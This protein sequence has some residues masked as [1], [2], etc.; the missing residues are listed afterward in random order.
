[1]RI[2]VFLCRA[3][4]GSP[5]P[6]FS[7]LSRLCR[8]VNS[9]FSLVLDFWL[10]RKTV[11]IGN[12]AELY[13]KEESPQY[14]TLDAQNYNSA[15]DQLAALKKSCTL[16]VGNLS[17]FSKEMQIYET[18]SYV[19]PVKRL[20]MGLNSNT[21]TPCG[22]CF[23]EYYTQEAAYMALKYVS[24]TV[25]DDRIIRC[26]ADPGYLPGRQFGRG[27]SGGQVRDEWRNDYDPGRGRFILPEVISG[28]KRR[29][30][31]DDDNEGPGRGRYGRNVRYERNFTGQQRT[32]GTPRE[33][34]KQQGHRAAQREV[35]NATVKLNQ[36]LSAAR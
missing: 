1:M 29:R 5:R 25:C 36:S 23:V 34:R 33:S 13:H 8:A 4:C 3:I 21:K 16:Y 10:A 9:N 27:R 2:L 11:L 31:D 26:D 12:M 15:E 24:D 18:F 30:G 35:Q 20:I 17:F 19:A 22:F 6:S 28:S 14:I 32:G 7:L